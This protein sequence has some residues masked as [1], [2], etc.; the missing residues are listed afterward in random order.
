VS[1][2][3]LASFVHGTTLVTNAL[4]ERRGSRTGALVT[5][6]MEDLFDIARETRYDLFDLRLAFP[7]PIVPRRLRR[8]IPERIGHDGRV[9]VPLSVSAVR[10]AARELVEDGV[11][12][13]AVCFLHSY[14]EAGHETA[15]VEVIREAYP[16]L[17]VSASG[18]VSSGAG[19]GAG[20]R[21]R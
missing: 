19:D 6:G 4:I 21:R 8:G 15:A 11:E 13:I 2:G 1:I 7:E 14:R 20:P 16:S 10:Q 18:G 5:E 9:R 17:S 12:A 3:Q